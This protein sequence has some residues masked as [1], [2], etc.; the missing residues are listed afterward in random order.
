MPRATIFPL[1]F[2]SFPAILPLERNTCEM[3]HFA[4]APFALCTCALVLFVCDIRANKQSRDSN[5][6]VIKQKDMKIDRPGT[7]VI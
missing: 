4:F 7:I 5:G 1:T 3:K 6:A 2:T